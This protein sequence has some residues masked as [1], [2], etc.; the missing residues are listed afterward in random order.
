MSRQLKDALACGN[1]IGD[2]VWYDCEN[3]TITPSKLIAL[4]NKHGLDEKY[5]PDSIKPKSAFQKACKQAQAKDS[6]SSDTRRSVI[7]IIVD[8]MD[9]I[10]YGVVDLDVHEASESISPDFSDKVW[11]DKGTLTVHYDKGHLMSKKIKDVYNQLCGEY[12]TRDISRMIVRAM[13]KMCSV[14]LRRGG[15]VYFVPV[16][17]QDELK[18]LR[19]VVNSLGQCDMRVFDVGST[20]ASSV[21]TEAK[22][23]I[24]TKISSLKDDIEDLKLSIKEGTVRGKTIENGIQVRWQRYEEIKMRCSVLADALKIKANSLTGDLDSV[25]K[26]IKSEL[27]APLTDV[28]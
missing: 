2:L 3:A 18:A 16:A 8:G 28:A 4:F 24:N 27:E 1:K 5:F 7:K 10:V 12:T 19:G 15:V 23:Q 20:T 11:L 26:L 21:T 6:S 9:K 17:M 13:D 22:S 14:S 25:A